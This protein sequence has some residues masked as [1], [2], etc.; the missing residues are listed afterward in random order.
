MVAVDWALWWQ[1]FVVVAVPSGG[2]KLMQDVVMMF[3]DWFL[4]D[5][6]WKLDAGHLEFFNSFVCLVMIT[7]FMRNFSTIIIGLEDFSSL[8]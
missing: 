4:H 3:E 7:W 6:R 8:Q 5:A 2:N 1:I